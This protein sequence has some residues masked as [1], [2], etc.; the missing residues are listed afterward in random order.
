MANQWLRSLNILSCGGKILRLM[1]HS[2]LED[3]RT[4]LCFPEE[5]PASM[6]YPSLSFSPPHPFCFY[7][8]ASWDYLPKWMACFGEN[9]ANSV[10]LCWIYLWI[11]SISFPI[12]LLK[13]NFVL[14][15]KDAKTD[16]SQN[17]QQT[18]YWGTREPISDPMKS[19][20]KA[21]T[22]LFGLLLCKILTKNHVF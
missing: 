19:I 22:F 4:E 3:P 9:Q 15:A 5:Q 7:T 17:R 1:L 20:F 13:R 18:S 11:Q 14:F 16:I 21:A 12:G 10:L 2:S 8:L 6:T